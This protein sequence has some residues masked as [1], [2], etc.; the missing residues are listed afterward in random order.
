MKN[1]GAIKKNR[2]KTMW[3]ARLCPKYGVEEI[4]KGKIVI[5]HKN[6][7]SKAIYIYIEKKESKKQKERGNL[8]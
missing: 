4:E 6:N 8:K 7:R 5:K 1:E 2:N 3:F